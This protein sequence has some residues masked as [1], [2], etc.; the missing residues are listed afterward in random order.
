MFQNCSSLI[1]SHDLPA[2]NLVSQCCAYMFQNCTSLT[3]A[4]ILSATTLDYAC[5]Y[6][7]FK[8]C[9]SLVNVQKT[10]PAT[11]LGELCCAYMFQDCTS[12]TTAPEL[13]ATTLIKSCYQQMFMGC[14]SLTTA[15]E[16]PATTLAT[17]C[18]Q[19]M[20]YGCTALTTAPELPATTLPELCYNA[21]FRNCTSLNYIKCLATDMSAANCLTNWVVGVASSGTFVKDVNTNWTTGTNGIPS[22]WVVEQYPPYEEQYL[23]FEA[24]EDGTFTFTN[25]ALQYSLDN[26]ATWTTLAADTASPTV[27]AGNKI[28]WKQTG[29]TPTAYGVGIFSSTGKSQDGEDL[30]PGSAV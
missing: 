15:P 25:N 12:L 13:P 18:Y 4:P 26:G 8:G 28:L 20:F 2:I 21:L 3:T 14:T 5:Y 29:L 19:G 27:S 11:T 22:G 1:N 24:L 9:T 16:L 17:Y 30:S 6:Q 7:M 10:I 23:T